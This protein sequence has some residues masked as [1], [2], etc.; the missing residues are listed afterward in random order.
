MWRIVIKG[1]GTRDEFDADSD[2]L[3][4]LRDL[5]P[6]ASPDA[7]GSAHV[8]SSHEGAPDGAVKPADIGN[9]GQQT[10]H[11]H[12]GG[13]GKR[14]VMR[15]LGNGEGVEGS[16]YWI[17]QARVRFGK[18]AK[19]QRDTRGVMKVID[20]RGP[21]VPV[22]PIFSSSTEFRGRLDVF[23]IPNDVIDFSD[24]IGLRNGLYALREKPYRYL[25]RYF[26]G[27]R[28]EDF[29]TKWG[30]LIETERPKVRQWLLGRGRP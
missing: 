24:L 1:N 19:K 28:I 13:G 12:G 26:E 8:P 10:A 6:K 5:L 22:L 29:G 25:K 17:S 23:A 14:S 7:Y 4:A 15:R 27:V 20:R 3:K 30:Q 2:A 18:D 11:S 9:L 21:T 16:I